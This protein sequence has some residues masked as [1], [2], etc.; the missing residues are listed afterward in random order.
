MNHF[1]YIFFIDTFSELGV[2]IGDLYKPTQLGS[3]DTS[4]VLNL[5][6]AN[7]T[8]D[9]NSALSLGPKLPL[10]TSFGDAAKLMSAA[11]IE[12]ISN[13]PPAEIAKNLANVDFNNM[14]QA[15]QAALATKVI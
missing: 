10:N 5:A 3:L 2:G 6:K 13:S 9:Q 8:F 12:I 11:P 4:S 1:L 7:V 15:K 14:N